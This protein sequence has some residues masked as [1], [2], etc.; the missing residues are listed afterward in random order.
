MET[1]ERDLGIPRKISSFVLPLGATVNMDGTALLQGV[2]AIFIAQFYGI[3][4]NLM[5]QITIVFMGILASIGTAPVPGVGM[6]ML[7]G[8]LQSVGLP[9]EG[10]GIIIGVDRILDMSRTITNITGDLVVAVIVSKVSG[11]NT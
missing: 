2:A 10:I 6:V 3:D 8:I 1:A 5:Q 9:I 11:E 7:I 4:L